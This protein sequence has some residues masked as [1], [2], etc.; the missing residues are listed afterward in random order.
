MSAPIDKRTKEWINVAERLK[1]AYKKTIL[2]A[3][4]LCYIQSLKKEE[5]K[6]RALADTLET[7]GDTNDSAEILA[8][9]LANGPEEFQQFLRRS[10]WKHQLP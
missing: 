10:I 3:A 5:R 6:M 2:K 8:N 7:S 4:W 1:R 9:Y